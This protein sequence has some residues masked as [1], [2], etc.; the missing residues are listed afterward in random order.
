MSDP[1]RKPLIPKIGGLGK[2]GGFAIPKLGS[3]KPPEKIADPLAGVEYSGDDEQDAARELD[4][5]A[6]AFR[7]RA[8]R[9]QE[10]FQ[11]ATDS[12]FWFCVCFKTR[13]QKER[14]LAALELLAQG[15]KYIDGEQLARRLKI[16]LPD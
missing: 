3:F 2:G 15:D 9:E 14:F 7:E 11:R 6:K 1:P 4:A 12:E 13:E 8:K 16:E 5:V 10:R